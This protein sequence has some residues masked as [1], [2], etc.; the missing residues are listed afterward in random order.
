MT[1]LLTAAQMRS[2]EQAAIDAD[3]VTGLE[4]MERAGQGVVD[5]ILDWRP[6]LA[7]AAHRAV[8]LCGP[9]NN[10]GDGFV[11]A[12]LLHQKGWEVEVLLY[13]RDPTETDALP[14]DA[15]E[16]ARRWQALGPI[17]RL[18]AG[19]LDA[20]VDRALKQLPGREEPLPSGTRFL[21]ARTYRWP[22]NPMP[23]IE[24]TRYTVFIDAIFG[25][26]QNRALPADLTE[27]IRLEWSD[28]CWEW[29]VSVDLPTG[30]DADSGV[31]RGA[32]PYVSLCVTFQAPKIGHYLGHWM[33]DCWKLSVVDLGLGDEPG[34]EA[35]GPDHLFDL[36]HYAGRKIGD[37]NK[38]QFG[39]A[40]V[41][42]GGSGQGGAARLAARAALR[43]GVG[44]VTIGAPPDA[45][46]ENAARLDA[47]MLRSVSNAQSLAARLKDERIN[48]ICLGP[49]L[50]VERARELV[51]VAC[52]RGRRH[53]GVVL[54]ADALTAFEEE[55]EALFE[56]TTKNC[57]LTPHAGEFK[58]VFPDLY[59]RLQAPAAEGPIISKVDVTK[60]AAKRAG[61]VVLFKGAS[62]VTADPKGR[63]AISGARYER[64]APWL[65]T[66]GSGDV[67]AGL[68]TG[69]MAR[70]LAP[71]DAAAAGAWL[72]VECARKFGPGLIAEDL[73][74]MLPAVFADLG[75]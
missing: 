29:G 55:P 32:A 16:N 26:G 47:V 63:A 9:G 23:S 60:A 19:A 1:N 66:A 48:T 25:I 43:V 50:G 21:Q 7:E 39:H 41:L 69:L 31:R 27:I 49:G 8:V 74:E 45:M 10:G 44:L 13:G 14:G 75:L 61:C 56:L 4:L 58:R 34:V 24:G 73:P 11:V 70:G 30:V 51:A 2:L 54:D 68:I 71:F 18:V 72:H 17:R 5:A 59:A 64:A 22:P 57:V 46:V 37:R 35:A 12:R 20:A 67:L 42:A 15:A 53:R 40:F 52:G 62:T 6:A 65:A 38:Y 28:F 3:E 33:E 36:I